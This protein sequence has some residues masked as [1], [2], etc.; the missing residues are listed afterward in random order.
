MMMPWL[1]PTLHVHGYSSDVCETLF[2]VKMEDW[3]IKLLE[4]G[5]GLCVKT[6]NA[7]GYVGII[8]NKYSD[9]HTISI[10]IVWPNIVGGK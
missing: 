1:N 2:I 6:S 7:N 5:Q 10:D 4:E 8:M 3:I 9:I